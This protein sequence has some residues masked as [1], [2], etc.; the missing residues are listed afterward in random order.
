MKYHKPGTGGSTPLSMGEGFNP[1]PPAERPFRLVSAAGRLCGRPSWLPPGDPGG[2]SRR[3]GPPR[4][5]GPLRGGKAAAVTMLKQGRHRWQ[6]SLRG[7]VRRLQANRSRVLRLGP[8]AHGR[9][10]I[11]GLGFGLGLGRGRLERAGLGATE[12]L[13]RVRA[14]GRRGVLFRR[15]FRRLLFWFGVR[16]LVIRDGVRTS[17]R[18][19]RRRRFGDHPGNQ[20]AACLLLNGCLP[21]IARAIS[22]QGIRAESGNL[23]PKPVLCE[24]S[25]SLLQ[26]CNQLGFA[27]AA[28]PP[29]TPAKS[30]WFGAYKWPRAGPACRSAYEA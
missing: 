11:C 20:L 21:I 8:R 26:P 5:G 30:S 4:G 9:A 27:M 23:I 28:R 16:E 14:C 7:P 15:T 13:G 6:W 25:V 19:R 29:Q 22:A 18:Q 12:L 1:P 3:Q 10:V 17:N 24:D 2:S